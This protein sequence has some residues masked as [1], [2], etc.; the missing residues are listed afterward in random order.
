MGL[1]GFPCNRPDFHNI[2]YL[3]IIIKKNENDSTFLAFVAAGARVV[4][5]ESLISCPCSVVWGHTF[6]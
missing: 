3:H 4:E 1:E 6:D 2:V 5:R